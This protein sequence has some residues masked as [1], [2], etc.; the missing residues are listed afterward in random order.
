MPAKLTTEDI[1]DAVAAVL[2]D[3]GSGTEYDRCYLTAYQILDRLPADLRDQL[4]AER[5][6]PG[7]SSG[8]NYSAAIHVGHAAV[9]AGASTMD[10]DIRG[11]TFTVGD[12]TLSG[13]HPV[14]R[15][16]ILED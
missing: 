16:Y 1:A 6:E 2:R 13:G 12:R 7:A 11:L 15:L 14:I 9:R 5:G 4:I 8:N 3:A 10:L